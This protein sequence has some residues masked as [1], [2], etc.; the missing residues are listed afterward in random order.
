MIG[1][2]FPTDI[3]WYDY[4]VDRPDLDEVAGL[5]PEGRMGEATEELAAQ[6]DP[7]QRL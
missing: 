2:L 7:R 1:R 6:R 3:D 4:L 5:L